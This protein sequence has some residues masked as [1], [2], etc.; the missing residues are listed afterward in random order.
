[1]HQTVE[2][3]SFPFEKFSSFTRLKRVMAY[4]LR[5]IDSCKSVKCKSVI[6][7]LKELEHAT[8]RLVKIS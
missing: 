5:F 1:M 8:L 6:L 4:C 2:V 3:L 7:S